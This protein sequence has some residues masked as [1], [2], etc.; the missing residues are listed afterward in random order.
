M[1]DKLKRK[2]ELR[3]K[4]EE[5]G[6]ALYQVVNDIMHLYPRQGLVLHERIAFLTL[7]IAL[8][9]VIGKYPDDEL[10]YLEQYYNFSS[11]IHNGSPNTSSVERGL[12]KMTFEKLLG[13]YSTKLHEDTERD[14]IPIIIS[15]IKETN[16]HF[17]DDKKSL[18]CSDIRDIDEVYSSFFGIEK[19]PLTYGRFIAKYEQL[20]K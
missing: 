10:P 3:I 16:E 9:N 19:R 14:L 6:K 20:T 12:F 15:I 8:G 11:N 1:F 2:K 18:S 4:A 13:E 5:D 17:P 7:A